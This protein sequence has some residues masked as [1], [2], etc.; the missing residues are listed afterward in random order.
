MNEHSRAGVTCVQDTADHS[1]HDDAEHG[2]RLQEPAQDAAA[3][4]V[5]QVLPCQAALDENLQ[6]KRGGGV[7]GGAFSEC[8]SLGRL[9]TDRT[10]RLGPAA[11]AGGALGRERSRKQLPTILVEILDHDAGPGMQAQVSPREA[12]N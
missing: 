5:G 9:C 8:V 11:A 10:G 7:G 3:F 6:R 12:Q 4:H 1:W 2:Q